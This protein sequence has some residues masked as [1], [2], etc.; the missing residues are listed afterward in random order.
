MLRRFEVNVG[1]QE[2]G[3]LLPQLDR[4]DIGTFLVEQEGGHINR[5]LRMHRRGVVL[6]GFLFK[7][8]QDM[9]GGGFGAANVARARAARAGDVAGLG[10]C[11]AQ[12]LARQF[13]QAEAADLA[14]LHARAVEAQRLADAVL[15]FALIALI[16]HVDEVD[17]DQAAEVAQAQ[18]PGDFFGGFEVGLECG[19]LDVGTTCRAAGVHIDRYQRFGVVDDDRPARGQADLARI[20]GLDLMLDLET[21]EQ[22]HI[23]AIALDAVDGARH[24]MFH[25]LLRL[26]EDLVSVDQDLADIG[27]EVIADRA[28]H[29]AA[30]LVDQEGAFLLLGSGLDGL[31]QLQE[32]VEVPLQF[33]GVAS[34]RCGA[35]NQAHARR[36]QQLIHHF[37]QLGALGALDAP[38]N[39][40]AARIVGHQHQISSGETDE[41]GQCRTLV[42][43]LVLVDLDDQ[44]LPFAQGLL[45]G[46]APGFHARLEERARNFLEGQK[47]VPFRSVIDERRFQAGF[48][49]GNDRFIYVAFFLFLVGRFDVQVNQL[50]TIDDGDTE[51]L[52]LCRVKQHAFHILAPAR[53]HGGRALCRQ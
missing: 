13:E 42:A 25:E 21:R 3:D 52:G 15:D 23:V 8:A 49:A 30:F 35:R 22:G 28:D 32:V 4:L 14:G 29:Q 26:V 38:R 43:T 39:T 47:A 12:A 10:E 44:F 34:D 1:N 31:P 9:Q 45:D 2:D 11:R 17:D 53:Y 41:G 20:G 16:F 51:F 40:A 33:F 46:R 36:D 18:L 7:D 19:F 24:H 37:P 27:L 50:L 6:H 48:Q 5:H